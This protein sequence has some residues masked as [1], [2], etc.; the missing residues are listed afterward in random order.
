MMQRLYFAE[1]RMI[2]WNLDKRRQQTQEL[3]RMAS[4]RLSELLGG[5]QYTGSLVELATDKTRRVSRAKQVD[6]DEEFSEKLNDI[7]RGEFARFDKREMDRLRDI[8]RTRSKI[9]QLED[10][11]ATLDAMKGERM[12]K[13][14]AD[15]ISNLRQAIEERLPR[16][17]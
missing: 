3:K 4:E 13:P 16:A 14:M 12:W 7:Q 9:G 6:R 17:P 1:Q 2:D 11:T 10:T 8:D 15:E 5:R